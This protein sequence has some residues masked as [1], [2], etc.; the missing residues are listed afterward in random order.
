MCWNY[1]SKL[2]S[3][4][5]RKKLKLSFQIFIL[6]RFN[7]SFYNYH[8]DI[9]CCD[10]F[11]EKMILEQDVWMNKW[12]LWRFES[13]IHLSSAYLVFF[14]CTHMSNPRNFYCYGWADWPVLFSGF[15]H[16]I[17]HAYSL[18]NLFHSLFQN[19]WNEDYSILVCFTRHSFTSFRR[20]RPSH[21]T[22]DTY[23]GWKGKSNYCFYYVFYD[24]SIHYFHNITC[25]FSKRHL[26]K[27]QEMGSK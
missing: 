3:H 15:R 9:L 20:N 22:K 16:F 19:F 18:F 6:S 8:P 24:L 1:H 13:R 21:G 12:A 7:F 17:H 5:L 2:L 4:N 23:L 26:K 14:L 11:S 10:L 27:M 25:W